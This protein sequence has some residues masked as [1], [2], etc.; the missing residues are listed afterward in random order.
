MADIV[1]L[2]D[3]G[4]VA[5]T[6]GVGAEE[7]DAAARW[8]DAGVGD[9][10]AVPE[11]DALMVVLRTPEA[12]ELKEGDA[13]SLRFAGAE[14]VLRVEGEALASP[15][16][17]REESEETEPES[18]RAG[19]TEGGADV[20]ADKVGLSLR[21]AERVLLP[22]RDTDGEEEPLR[23]E[24]ADREI[25]GGA[26]TVAPL[27]D[28]TGVS[29]GEE[30]APKVRLGGCD[31]Q[32]EA[33]ASN[34]TEACAED[35]AEEEATREEVAM[36]EKEGPPLPIGAEENVAGFPLAV[37]SPLN[38]EEG[39]SDATNDGEGRALAVLPLA[40]APLLPVEFSDGVAKRDSGNTLLD[41]ELDKVVSKLGREEAVCRDG[42]EVAVVDAQ[43][44]PLGDSEG[45]AE[46]E[47][48]ADN[49]TA[50]TDSDGAAVPD[51]FEA[52]AA[53][54]ADGAALLLPA[55][56]TEGLTVRQALAPPLALVEAVELPEGDARLVAEAPVP[57]GATD[58][59]SA[60]LPDGCEEAEKRGERDVGALRDK[61]REWGGEREPE[62]LR[63]VEVDTEGDTDT[64]ALG[65]PT[66]LQVEQG[67][68]DVVPVPGREREA[69]RE[70]E[71]QDVEVCE[72][73]LLVVSAIE[74][75]GAPEPLPGTLE[76]AL[77]V[78]LPHEEP[79]KDAQ[80][81]GGTERDASNDAELSG[82]AFVLNDGTRDTLASAVKDGD[83]E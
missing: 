51:A 32:P 20:S 15:D 74:T 8:V 43:P 41:A 72:A 53:R 44:L 63:V 73:M 3:A 10:G 75:V 49:V 45:E 58:R 46:T 18:V 9:T 16:A 36:P 55:V 59:V 62:L 19:D 35:P 57:E 82:D 31:A 11:G 21:A 61:E 50:P 66:V 68:E 39:E 42:E 2:R 7:S 14:G 23:L 67:E 25:E 78:T 37:A 64:C 52:L 40:V 47:E 12:E 6:G 17:E 22:L 60:L 26:E 30:L 24:V 77:S 56:D 13:L 54:L 81:L 4:A 70:T 76:D 71:G 28:G 27:K 83:N 29:V 38:K 80:P 34:E 5:E 65:V 69:A 33:L 79:L 1:P 48:H